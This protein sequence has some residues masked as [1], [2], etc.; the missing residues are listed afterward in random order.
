MKENLIKTSNFFIEW[1][2]L[3]AVF[4]VPLVFFPFVSDLGTFEFSKQMVLYLLVGVMLFFWTLRMVLEGKV[5][6]KRTIVDP[7]IILLLFV[8]LLAAFFS[9]DRWTSVFGDH[10]RLHGG[11]ISMVIYVLFYFIVVSHITEKKQLVRVLGMMMA[12]AVLL[13]VVGMVRLFQTEI[14]PVDFGESIW[15]LIG[16]GEKAAMWLS[17]LFPVL[18]GLILYVKGNLYK[19]VLTACGVLLLGYLGL[20]NYYPAMVVTVLAVI[21]FIVFT[22]PRIIASH[23]VHILILGVVFILVAAFSN[24]PS[25][26]QSVPFFNDLTPPRELSLNHQT[27]WVTVLG[28]FNL[29]K[30]VF[31]GSGPATYL[32][33]F[34]RFRPLGLNNTPFWNLKFSRASNEVF[35]MLSTVGILGF[36][37]FFMVFIWSLWRTAGE[38]FRKEAGEETLIILG[39][40]LGIVS[41]LTLFLFT[42]T[43]TATMLTLWLLLALIFSSFGLWGKHNLTRSVR[44]SLAAVPVAL[45]LV[46]QKAKKRNTL[47]WVVF[48]GVGVLL[49][50]FFL[51][52]GKYFLADLSYKKATRATTIGDAVFHSSRAV[53][54]FPQNATYR[55]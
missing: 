28:G 52:E 1:G 40:F 8:Y 4:L 21:G 3:L 20:L 34:S 36:L 39:L 22:R 31:L 14:G 16:S 9:L 44:L 38:L 23:A 43:A 5:E 10:P 45:D 26:K 29:P 12:S 15:A 55:I 32:Y 6:I 30:N 7:F 17:M 33:D 41:G 24:V 27:S 53:N 35:Q 11:L 51:F 54:L 18:I 46:S 25:L 37:A 13:S 42:T 2:I 48:T 47:S 49:L 50:I 19:L